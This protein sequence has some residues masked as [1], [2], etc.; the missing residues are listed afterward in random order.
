MRVL[1][2]YSDTGRPVMLVVSE[3]QLKLLV[4]AVALK[5]SLE[6]PGDLGPFGELFST[7]STRG[8]P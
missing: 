6:G 3:P 4:Q 1:D 5:A 8:K 7:L 2:T